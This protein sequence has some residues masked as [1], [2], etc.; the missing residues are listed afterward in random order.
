MK[1]IIR[2]FSICLVVTY[3]LVISYQAFIW[4]RYKT[5]TFMSDRVFCDLESKQIPPTNTVYEKVFGKACTCCGAPTPL[6]LAD[7]VRGFT[8][9]IFLDFE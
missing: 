1:K 9:L 8:Q 5:P 7:G 6:T 2:I 3:L 4:Q